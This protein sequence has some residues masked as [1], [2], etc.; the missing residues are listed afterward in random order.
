MFARLTQVHSNISLGFLKIASE[1]HT[2][3]Y[4]LEQATFI[5]Q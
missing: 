1:L 4:V 3:Y 2:S 5:L